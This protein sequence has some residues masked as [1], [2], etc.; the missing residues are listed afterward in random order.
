MSKK[1]N[2]LYTWF[3]SFQ[4]YHYAHAVKCDICGEIFKVSKGYFLKD[5]VIACYK[6]MSDKFLK[7]HG[8]DVKKK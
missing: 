2:V 5:D 3:E 1:K 4:G 8:F 6:H 7:E